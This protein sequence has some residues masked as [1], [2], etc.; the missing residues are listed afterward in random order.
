MKTVITLFLTLAATLQAASIKEDT[1][2]YDASVLSANNHYNSA[3]TDLASTRGDLAYDEYL[4]GIQDVQ[5]ATQQEAAIRTYLAAH[6]NDSDSATLQHHVE[7]YSKSLADLKTNLETLY[8]RLQVQAVPRLVQ[9]PPRSPVH[10]DPKES[11]EKKQ[12][13]GVNAHPVD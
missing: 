9:H 1:D 3:L 4:K 10:A 12:G 6:P 2:N 11:P 7:K 8:L 13:P 5:S